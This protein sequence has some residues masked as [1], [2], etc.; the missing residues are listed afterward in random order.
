MKKTPIDLKHKSRE[1][2]HWPDKAPAR[3]ML[4]AVGLNTKDLDSPFIGIA[5]SASEVTP[6][7]LGLYQVAQKV[8]AGIRSEGGVPFEFGTITVS[9]GI[10]MGTEGMKASLI[11]REV[12]ADSVEIVAFAERLDGLVTLAGCDKNLPGMLMAAIRLNIPSVFIYGG[13]SLPGCRARSRSAA[14]SKSFARASSTGHIT[15]TCSTEL[16][17][18]TTRRPL[19]CLRATDSA[20]RG[21]FATAPTRRSWPSTSAFS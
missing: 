7:N 6:C 5:N 8:K 4:R 9:D 14:R 3:A 19:S 20:S 17:L 13:A 21:S 2:T 18:P 1:V 10:S 12:I 15:S 11:S 16:R